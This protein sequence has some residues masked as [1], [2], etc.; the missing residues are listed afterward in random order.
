M[1]HLSG[2][3]SLKFSQLIGKCRQWKM[4]DPITSHMTENGIWHSEIVDF[5]Q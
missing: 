4:K 3:Y 2:T 1:Q 5:G